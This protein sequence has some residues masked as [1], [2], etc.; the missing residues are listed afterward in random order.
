MSWPVSQSA[1]AAR[2][3]GAR[4]PKRTT[5]EAR[6]AA[7]TVAPGQKVTRTV[8]PSRCHGGVPESRRAPE[9]TE[10]EEDRRRGQH[11]ND[12]SARSGQSVASREAGEA[13]RVVSL[14]QRQV[15]VVAGDTHEEV[16][17]AAARRGRRAG[18]QVEAVLRQGRVS[19]SGKPV[20]PGRHREERCCHLLKLV[21]PRLLSHKRGLL[22]RKAGGALWCGGQQLASEKAGRVLHVA[23][24]S[25][26]VL[27]G[28]AS[29]Q[30]R[31][32]VEVLRGGRWGAALGKASRDKV[33]PLRCGFRGRRGRGVCAL[34]RM[35]V[36]VNTDAQQGRVPGH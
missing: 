33:Q 11:G 21:G 16:Q 28:W 36:V 23:R 1:I 22:R 19:P 3:P 15:P 26:S 8:S 34:L 6:A 35:R 7:P 2:G 13:D 25:A 20:A 24:V 32:V 14:R 12:G 10:G 18:P 31:E 9:Y 29:Q 5:D 27:P 30:N 4:V 17:R